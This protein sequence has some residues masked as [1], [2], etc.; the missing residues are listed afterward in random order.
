M[1]VQGGQI[2]SGQNPLCN[3][4]P[5]EVYR[6]VTI[7]GMFASAWPCS[8]FFPVLLCSFEYDPSYGYPK[9]VTID[10]PIPDA[11]FDAIRVTEVKLTP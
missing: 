10:C 6:P 7:E 9:K 8:F 3:G 5:L 2:V 1:T 4:C 11:C